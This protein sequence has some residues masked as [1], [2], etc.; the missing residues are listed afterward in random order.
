[1]EE[2]VLEVTCPFN[3]NHKLRPERIIWHMLKC[4]K[5]LSEASKKKLSKVNCAYN[6]EHWI[7]FSEIH[8]HM[9]NEC[10]ERPSKIQKQAIDA[11]N[12]TSKNQ[13]HDHYSRPQKAKPR[14]RPKS[15][16]NSPQK[17]EFQF[18]RQ[19]IE[20]RGGYV[21]NKI[22]V[23]SKP[24]EEKGG[25]TLNKVS[26]A[27]NKEE[28]KAQ[29]T[30]PRRDILNVP[31]RRNKSEN[32]RKNLKKNERNHVETEKT[33]LKNREGRTMK[34]KYVKKTEIIQ[35]SAKVEEKKEDCQSQI[36]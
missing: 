9:E 4:S 24:V 36:F 10:L 19:K 30:K 29:L 13:T 18:E 34:P 26:S 21:L 28:T 14:P 23:I 7:D 22:S 31:K 15:V 5:Y 2:P 6:K 8:E 32:N 17:S 12:E 16:D 11:I 3:S 35:E 1:M 33:D 25:Y 27:R 20:E